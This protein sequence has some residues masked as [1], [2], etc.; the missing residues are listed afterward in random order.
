MS[1]DPVVREAVKAYAKAEDLDNREALRLIGKI[2]VQYGLPAGDPCW[3]AENIGRCLP[4]P[5]DMAIKKFR[6]ARMAYRFAMCNYDSLIKPY[7]GYADVIRIELL[8]EPNTKE[9]I[10]EAEK[11]VLK[12]FYDYTAMSAVISGYKTPENGEEIEAACYA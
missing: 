4:T 5:L 10:R 12:A 6:K 7:N 1:V 11:I 9:K 3:I 8:N 2:V